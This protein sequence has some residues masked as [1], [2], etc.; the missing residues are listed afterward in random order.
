[1]CLHLEAK[2]VVPLDLKWNFEHSIKWS[3]TIFYPDG[4]LKDIDI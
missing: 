4:M 2:D 1:M 3:Q